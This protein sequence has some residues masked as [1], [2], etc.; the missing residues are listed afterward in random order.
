M[1]QKAKAKVDAK[2]QNLSISAGVGINKL[3]TPN[4][5]QLN[6]LSIFLSKKNIM[7]Q[8]LV[9]PLGVIGDVLNPFTNSVSLSA[10]INNR[11]ISNGCLMKPSQLVNR[12]RV[13]VGGD[14][15]RTFYTMVSIVINLFMLCTKS[16]LAPC[17]ASSCNVH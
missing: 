8:N 2:E 6:Y 9:D 14:D 3:P 10:I 16:K 15:L 1:G 12:P 13:N 7:P 17:L 5:V 4:E 11:E